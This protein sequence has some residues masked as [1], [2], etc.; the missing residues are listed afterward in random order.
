M[1]WDDF[2]YFAIPSILLWNGAAVLALRGDRYA[3]VS[4]IMLAVGIAVFAIF[5]TM[6][7]VSLSRPPLRTMGETR[8]WYSFLLVVVGFVIYLK[9]RFSVILL[10]STI[11]ASVFVII[12]L[13]RPEIHDQTLMPALQSGWFVPHVIVYMLA[14]GILGYVFLSVCYMQYKPEESEKLTPIITKLVYCGVGLLSIGMLFGA[15]WAKQAWGSYWTW[16]AKETWALI[17][18]FIYLLYIHGQGEKQKIESREKITLIVGFIA[19][20]VCWY[21]VNYL[22]AATS[23]VHS[24]N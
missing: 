8:L 21:G 14:Y 20:Q 9:W 3:R 10:F 17:T 4:K 18:W 1:S 2:I 16:D 11:T 23:S 6:L 24:Y 15:I 12:N 7:W 13:L 19:L 5:I 22:P